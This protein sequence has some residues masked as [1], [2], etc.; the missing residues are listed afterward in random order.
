MT[1]T[2]ANIIGAVSDRTGFTKKRSRH[3]VNCLVENIKNYK[4]SIKIIFIT[5]KKKYKK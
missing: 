1:L 2:K 4:S 3:S 5:L